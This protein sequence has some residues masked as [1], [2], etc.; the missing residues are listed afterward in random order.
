MLHRNKF[1]ISPGK[2]HNEKYIKHNAIVELANKEYLVAS[3]SGVH[4][5]FVWWSIFDLCS[6]R[7]MTTFL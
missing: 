6:K 5:V 4:P 2:L 7:R 1:L 3:I